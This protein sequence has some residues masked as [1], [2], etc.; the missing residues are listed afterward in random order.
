VCQ[1]DPTNPETQGGAGLS[2]QGE[3]CEEGEQV[4]EGKGRPEV[5]EGQVY[6]GCRRDCVEKIFNEFDVLGPLYS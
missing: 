5:L 6:V 1:P 2:V 3:G 4:S